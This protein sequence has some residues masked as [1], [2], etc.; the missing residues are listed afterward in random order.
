[1]AVGAIVGAPAEAS[2]HM[3]PSTTSTTTAK[4]IGPTGSEPAS[5]LSCKASTFRLRTCRS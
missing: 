2:S 1:L 5:S 3:A 4:V